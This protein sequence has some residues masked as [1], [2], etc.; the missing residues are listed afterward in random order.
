MGFWSALLLASIKSK[1]NKPKIAGSTQPPERIVLRDTLIRPQSYRHKGTLCNRNSRDFRHFGEYHAKNDLASYW[2][3]MACLCTLAL[4]VAAAYTHTVT[5]LHHTSEPPPVTV[6]FKPS[7]K[8]TL[9]FR[10]VFANELT[11][12]WIARGLNCKMF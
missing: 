7:N 9:S 5:C 8:N 3:K 1:Q 12:T 11:V 6:L 4:T 10:L 2:Q